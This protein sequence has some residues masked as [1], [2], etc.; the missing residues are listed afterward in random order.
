M[1]YTKEVDGDGTK[2]YYKNW[3]KHRDGDNPAVIYS[4]GTK[5]YFKNGELHRDGNEPAIIHSKGYKFYFKNGVQYTKEQVEK[6]EEIRTRI[7]NRLALKYARYWYD[8]TY[9]DTEGEAFK[10]RM[11]RD[12]DYLENE[13]GYVF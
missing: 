11:M 1:S 3:K 2:Y 8:E 9:R 10:A 13:I 4:D 6:M 5:H 12:M 7:A